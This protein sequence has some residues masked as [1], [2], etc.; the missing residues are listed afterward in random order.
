MMRS[1]NTKLTIWIAVFAIIFTTITTI[2]FFN[3]VPNPQN[4][5]EILTVVWHIIC[6]GISFA[7]WLTVLIL[8]GRGYS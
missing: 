5:I 8:I 7:L 2:L 1:D 6:A 4:T 3:I